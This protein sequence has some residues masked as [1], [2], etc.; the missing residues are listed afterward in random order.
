MY[1]HASIG[2]TRS[3]AS[4]H[5]LCDGLVQA[6]VDLAEALKR[7]E[8]KLPGDRSGS[9]RL[10][11]VWVDRIWEEASQ[12]LARPSLGLSLGALAHSGTFDLVGQL[13][14]AS[15]TL[16][17]AFV[18]LGRYG[19]LWGD[20]HDL[21]LEVSDGRATVSF[22]RPTVE[23]PGRQAGEAMLAGLL[24]LAESLIA[25]RLPLL[26]V[27]FSHEE[28]ADTA[29]HREL[30]RAP[31]LFGASGNAMVFDSR[32]LHQP[33]ANHDRHLCRVLEQQA[34]QLVEAMPRHDSYTKRVQHLIFVELP[35]GSPNAD[36]VA[37]KLGMT[38][39][40]LSRRLRAEGTSHQ[41]LLDAMRRKVADGYLRTTAMS[42]SEIAYELGFA[43]TSSF[44]RAFKRWTGKT[45]SGYRQGGRTPLPGSPQLN[46][47]AR[48]PSR[49]L[50][51]QAAQG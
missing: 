16:G 6:G 15:S 17:D 7:A 32:F 18:R 33:L 25:E 45:P 4:V 46:G 30:F 51:S 5:Q 14:R 12:Q 27:H 24:K 41:H 43:D 19:R 38:T 21:R 37:R 9:Q 49:E 47:H 35:H 20:E 36:D 8:V 26:E 1:S 48:T 31:L 28:P 22:A 42:A 23:A 13:A 11:A 10:P 29:P 40:T 34:E 50:A 2:P 44:S 39:R 3:L